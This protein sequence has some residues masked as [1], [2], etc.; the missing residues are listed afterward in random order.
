M[1][2]PA[3][4]ELAQTNAASKL[5]Q[6]TI[7]PWSPLAESIFRALWI[8]TVA[9]NIGTWMQD[10]GESWLM[11]SL[12]TSPMLVALVET[13]GSLPIVL[14]ALPAGALADVVDR[15]RLLLITQSWMLVSAAVLGV[16]TLAGMVTPWLLLLLTFTLGLGTAMNGPAWQAIIPDLVPRHE[17]PAAVTLVGVAINVSRAVGP[18]LGGLLVAAAGS[19]VV[20]LLNAV[21][22]L[23]VMVVIYRWQPAPQQSTMLPEHIF[24]AMRAGLRYVRHA[25]ELLAAFVRTGAFIL[26]ASALWALLPL[27]ARHALDLGSFGYGILLGCLGTGAVAGAAFLPKVRLKVSNNLLVVGATVLFAAVTAVLAHVHVPVVAGAAMILGGIAW[28]AVMSSFNTAA[29]TAAPAWARA[30]A[31]SIYTLVFMGGM[32]VGSAA[33]GAVAAHFGVTSALTYAALGLIIGSAASLRYVLI[34]GDDLNLAPCMCWPE[35]IVVVKPEPEQGPV[36]VQIEY[37]IDPDQAREFRRAVRDLRRVRRRDGASRWALFRD[38]AKPGRF[39]EGFLIETW[40][41]HLRQHARAT[42]SDRQIEE[43]VRAFH[44][45][46]GQPVITHL[47]AERVSG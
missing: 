33:W 41:E 11:I 29:Q 28:I 26:C 13:A 16:F 40:A 46:D 39:V 15:R 7:S 47:I 21:S 2:R 4:T 18:A 17:L 35:P 3:H 31:L 27:Q 34:D 5:G 20:F 19:G 32:A 44:I 42:E 10:V 1:S 8:A 23:A 45:G 36:L 9:S 43:R 24:G 14:L 12:T 37:W 22:F 25:P 38:P 30:R 6:E